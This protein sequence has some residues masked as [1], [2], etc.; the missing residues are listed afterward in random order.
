MDTILNEYRQMRITS[1]QLREQLGDDLHNVEVSRPVCIKAFD[2]RDG[3]GHVLSGEKA[4][5]ELVDWVNVVW[6]TELFYFPDGETDSIISV[7]EVLE[8]LDEDGV[9]ISDKELKAMQLALD[10]N[11]EYSPKER[12][13]ETL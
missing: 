3:I 12:L 11:K 4:L 1:A 2:V 6:F 13:N 5:E 7:L 10:G 8:M 9:H